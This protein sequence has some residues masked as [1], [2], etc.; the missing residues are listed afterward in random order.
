MEFIKLEQFKGLEENI[1]KV[2]LNWWKPRRYDL[3]IDSADLS[4]VECLDY[5]KEDEEGILYH[6]MRDNMSSIAYMIPLLI[7]TRLR[8]FIEDKGYGMELQYYDD[9]SFAYSLYEFQEGTDKRNIV[10]EGTLLEAY[11]KVAL[12]IAKEE[13]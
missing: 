12:E 10:F 2:F 9:K 8:K 11:W 4:Q 13:I 3:Y 7:E 1:Q 6:S 5:I